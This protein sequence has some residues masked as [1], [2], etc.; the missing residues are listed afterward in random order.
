[1]KMIEWIYHD[2][3][4]FPKEFTPTTIVERVYKCGMTFTG[5]VI[6]PFRVSH[7][8]LPCYPAEEEHWESSWV[9]GRGGVFVPVV[10]Y[11]ILS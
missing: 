7:P 11:R 5:T 2:G 4:S 1:M 6:K 9:K 10:K 3:L 8:S